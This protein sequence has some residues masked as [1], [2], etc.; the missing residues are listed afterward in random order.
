[1]SA[2]QGRVL[3]AVSA[4]TRRRL[5]TAFAGYDLVWA[6][7]EAEV[8]AALCAGRYDL[9]VVGSH[10]DESHTFDIVRELRHADPGLRIVCVRGRPFPGALGHSTMKAFR[11]ACQAEGVCAVIDLLDYA[12][13]DVSNGAIR[14]IFERE[15]CANPPPAASA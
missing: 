5:L 3:L 4:Q 14:A 2:S 13:D 8:R 12:E 15:L 6:Q 11:S 9:S 10:F 7:T 1:M